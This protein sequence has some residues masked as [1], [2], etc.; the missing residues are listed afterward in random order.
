MDVVAL[1]QER[2]AERR[3]EQ[4]AAGV[5]SAAKGQ[6]A[7][8]GCRPSPAASPEPGADG[9]RFALPWVRRRT[10]CNRPET[11]PNA[12]P[13]ASAARQS[14]SGRTSPETCWAIIT[15]TALG[16]A[17]CTRWAMSVRTMPCSIVA[18]RATTLPAYPWVT[19]ISP[20]IAAPTEPN[21]TP[22]RWALAAPMPPHWTK[23]S[24]ASS[25]PMP[26]IRTS[27]VSAEASA[28][29]PR[30]SRRLE[31][32]TAGSAAGAGSGSAAGAAVGCGCGL[33]GGCRCGLCGR[34]ALV[35]HGRHLGG[36]C[37]VHGL[38]GALAGPSRGVGRLVCHGDPR[39]HRPAGWW[40]GAYPS[41]GAS[42]TAGGPEPA[43]DL[44]PPT[45][46]TVPGT[47]SDCCP[48]RLAGDAGPLA[49]VRD[50]VAGRQIRLRAAGIPR[51]QPPQHSPARRWDAGQA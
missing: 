33:R 41:H 30:S 20:A 5:F 9:P 36:R 2:S 24:S 44:R 1:H 42:P 38:G 4:I 15:S 19:R 18:S 3:A 12:A 27:T 6:P 26:P 50:P 46:A 28:M 47:P 8:A 37:S 14:R 10:S 23:T 7:K 21:S 49:G 29:P 34:G 51:C 17:M 11:R 45:S 39:V 43:P 13:N 22:T 31:M 40:Q 32:A 25:A 16:R 48:G 35:I